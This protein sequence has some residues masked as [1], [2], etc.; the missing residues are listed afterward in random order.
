MLSP[1]HTTAWQQA[2]MLAD[3]IYTH[4]GI[5][6]EIDFEH[7]ICSVALMLSNALA[8]SLEEKDKGELRR[9]LLKSRAY[10]GDLSAMVRSGVKL[11]KITSEKADTLIKKCDELSELIRKVM[12]Q[13]G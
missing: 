13:Y 5:S 7:Q 11:Q 12:K 10:C 1:E 9:I 2:R 8:H 3:R 4:F 6:H